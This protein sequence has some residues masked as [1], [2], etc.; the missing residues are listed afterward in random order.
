MFHEHS[1]GS[2]TLHSKE[3]NT[4]DWGSERETVESHQGSSHTTCRK[5]ITDTVHI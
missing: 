3:I 5:L 2:N 1:S 4:T